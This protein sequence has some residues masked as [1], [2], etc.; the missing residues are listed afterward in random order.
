MKSPM[1]QNANYISDK[2]R[3]SELQV[4]RSGAGYYVGTI[5]HGEDFDEPGSRDSDYFRTE[6][7]AAAYLSAINE[8]ESV[9]EAGLMTRAHP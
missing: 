7:E 5:Y 3:Y 8:N 9:A 1:V 2:G 4:L 6:Q